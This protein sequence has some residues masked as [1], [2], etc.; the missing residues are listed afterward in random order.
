MHRRLRRAAVG[1]AVV[2]L[3]SCG[4]SAPPVARSTPSAPAGAEPFVA[5][6]PLACLAARAG[7]PGHDAWVWMGCPP[8][9]A[10]VSPATGIGRNTFAQIGFPLD[11]RGR[12]AGWDVDFEGTRRSTRLGYDRAS[13]WN[14]VEQPDGVQTLVQWTSPDEVTYVTGEVVQH[15]EIEPGPEGA[16][17]LVRVGGSTPQDGAE[18]VWERRRVWVRFSNAALS[19]ARALTTYDEAGRIERFELDLNGDGALEV[20]ADYTWDDVEV[21]RGQWEPRITSIRDGE[22]SWEVSGLEGIWPD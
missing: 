11:D 22:G 16:A 4:A 1:L 13:R 2:A 15:F 9:A 7:V 3:V 19:D 18:L 6:D 8:Q 10:P 21:L 14:T 5:P 12:L 20:F 17:R